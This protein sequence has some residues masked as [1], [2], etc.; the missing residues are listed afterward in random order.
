MWA[1]M[2]AEW[3]R[4]R[5]GRGHRDLNLRNE[6]DY[7]GRGF[8]FSEL[9]GRLRSGLRSGLRGGW[10]G[11]GSSGLNGE[12]FFDGL[13][14]QAVGVIDAALEAGLGAGTL[15]EGLAGGGVGA[16]VAGVLH[17]MDQDL[18]INSVEAAEEPGGADDVIDQGAFDDGLG[19][20]ILVE[21]FGEGGEGG[22]ILA[23]DDGGRGVNSGLEGIHAG[24]G[25]ALDGARAGGV[26]RIAA[27]GVNLILCRHKKM[28]QRKSLMAAVDDVRALMASGC[29]QFQVNRGNDGCLA[30]KAVRC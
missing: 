13:P 28:G 30:G 2:G 15:V 19:L 6:P 17:H 3:R 1:D 24:G 5:R 27:V 22:G 26:L 10:L 25:L 18:G 16:G 7:E 14:L 9:R 8:D 23:G 4:R 11:L 12:Q 29:P 20:A 21:P